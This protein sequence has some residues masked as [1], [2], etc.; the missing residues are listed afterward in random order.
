MR[1]RPTLLPLLVLAFLLS[2]C[3]TPGNAAPASGPTTSPAASAD[4]SATAQPEARKRTVRM[5]IYDHIK[6]RVT[7]AVAVN[8]GHPGLATERG[9]LSIALGSQDQTFK[10]LP[11]SLVDRML[12]GLGEKGLTELAT[13][14]EAGDEPLITGNGTLPERFRWCLY[15]ELDGQRTKVVC[16]NPAGPDD[17]RGRA[18]MKRQSELRIAAWAFWNMRKEVEIPQGVTIGR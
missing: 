15:F 14:F 3:Q 10:V 12:K 17:D 2:A 1:M 11:E 16:R 4:A 13:P 9:R 8:E 18:L 7:R 5:V 6:D